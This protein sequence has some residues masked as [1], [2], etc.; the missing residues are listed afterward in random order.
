SN[1]A[2]FSRY[3]RI[4]VNNSGL[5]IFSSSRLFQNML[6]S[7]HFLFINMFLV[8]IEDKN[9]FLKKINFKLDERPV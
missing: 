8:Y 6:S 7:K 4:A 3:H 1:Y 9:H 2:A 5:H